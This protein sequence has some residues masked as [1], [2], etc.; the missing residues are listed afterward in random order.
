MAARYGKDGF[1]GVA[2]SSSGSV[3]GT[4][5]KV[6]FI[7]TWSFNLDQNIVDITSFGDVWKQVAPTVRTW[8][9]NASGTLDKTS[10]EEQNLA[11]ISQFDAS[12][13]STS[14]PRPIYVRFYE[15]TA[16]WVGMANL[17]KVSIRSQVADK[18][19]VTYDIQGTTGLSYVTT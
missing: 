2:S 13:G 19:S 15:S 18:V 1:I 16:Y 14:Y 8:T 17:T 12:G 6:T 9:G 11:M 4:T 3:I 5:E 7:D 10:T